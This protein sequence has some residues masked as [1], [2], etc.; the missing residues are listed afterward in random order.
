MNRGRKVKYGGKIASSSRVYTMQHAYIE[1]F[2]K[3]KE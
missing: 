1:A 2:Y 3:H